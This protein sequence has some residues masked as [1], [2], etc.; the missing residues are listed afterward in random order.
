MSLWLEDSARNV[1]GAWAIETKTAGLA[2]AAI[3]SPFSTP[4]EKDWKPGAV[5]TVERL[6]EAGL[7]VWLD[8]ETH[9]F[10][11]PSVGAF[12]YYQ[13]WDLWSSA[14]GA[15]NTEADRRDHTERVFAAQDALGLPHLA[16][17]ILLHSAQSQT[18]QEA[19][20]LSRVAVEID[21]GCR[22]AIAGD[23]T[24]WSAGHLLDGHVGA[25]AQLEPAGWFVTVARQISVVPVP[26]TGTEIHGLCRTVRA[27]S[28]ETPVHIS[29]GDLAGLPAIAAGGTT[30]GTG[31]DVRQK[32]SSYSSYLA[33]DPQTE[34]GGWF[35][36][37]TY[38][39]LLSCLVRGDAQVLTNRQPAL[40]AQLLPGTLPPGAAAKSPWLHHAG[41]LQRACE[42]L[43]VPHE[44][45][46]GELRTK[47]DA[48]VQAWESVASAL[49]TPS[50]AGEWITPLLDG[51]LAYGATEGY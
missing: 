50:R 35:G 12:R 28:A 21:P 3:L 44:Q 38:E 18:S 25:L 36:Q 4:Y 1:L 39:G 47:Y 43:A 41:V 46:Y 34:G 2:E 32:A 37:A 23:S 26:A 22:L 20:D 19:L 17:T 16:P 49:G 6:H 13:T 8:P 10:Q 29:H 27:L 48:A 9:V 31:W 15:L 14:F 11:M 45:A 24:F 7:E 40:A 51:L 5:E 33:L 30:L 42:A